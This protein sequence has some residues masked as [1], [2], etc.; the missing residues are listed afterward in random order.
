MGDLPI[1]KYK[2]IYPKEWSNVDSQFLFFSIVPL[3]WYL[4]PFLVQLSWDLIFSGSLQ[5]ETILAF[6]ALSYEVSVMTIQHVCFCYLS[7]KHRSP[8]PLWPSLSSYFHLFPWPILLNKN[9]LHVLHFLSFSCLGKIFL[10]S[11]RAFPCSIEY[12]P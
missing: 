5:L 1:L 7:W 12:C 9:S 8:F 10:V 4:L 11:Y 3:T 6:V 2:K